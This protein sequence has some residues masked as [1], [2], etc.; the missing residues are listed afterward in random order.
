MRN[1]PARVQIDDY[2][3]ETPRGGGGRG[4]GGAAAWNSGGEGGIEL[5]GGRLDEDEDHLL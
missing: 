4:G 2:D 5:S 1:V 3:D